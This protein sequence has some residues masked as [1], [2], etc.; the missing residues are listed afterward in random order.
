MEKIYSE[1]VEAVKES[2]K[3]LEKA[4]IIT[5][6]NKEVM[7]ERLEEFVNSHKDN[8]ENEL[9]SFINKL[10]L[11][12]GNILQHVLFKGSNE[13]KFKGVFIGISDFYYPYKTKYEQF[14]K[15][16]PQEKLTYENKGLCKNNNLIVN[17]KVLQRDF[18]V[19]NIFG[20]LENKEQFRLSLFNKSATDS[21]IKL[22]KEVSFTANKGTGLSSNTKIS[23]SQYGNNID[24]TKIVKPVEEIT[25]DILINPNSF[26]FIEGYLENNGKTPT[27]LSRVNIYSKAY[28][29]LNGLIRNE[30]LTE[31][32]NS[33]SYY[34]ILLSNMRKTNTEDSRLINCEVISFTPIN[35]EVVKEKKI[36]KNINPENVIDDITW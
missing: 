22:N 23:E 30:S 21:V 26:I 11:T 35:E 1:F 18:C 15:L 16:S 31:N 5:N 20:I 7:K 8:G 32:I 10:K 36:N 2:A 25:E 33:D 24:I 28:P 4:G 17:G 12:N 14:D 9:K 6:E 19:L 27:G 13:T 34:L 3:K 29:E